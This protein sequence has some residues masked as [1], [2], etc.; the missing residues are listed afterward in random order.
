MTG[1]ENESLMG[2]DQL[3]QKL[4]LQIGHSCTRGIML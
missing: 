3:H 4:R 2:G 1:E